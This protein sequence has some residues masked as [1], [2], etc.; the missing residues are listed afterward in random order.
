MKRLIPLMLLLFLGNAVSG[1]ITEQYFEGN[2]LNVTYYDSEKSGQ[3]VVSCTVFDARGKAVY[4]EMAFLKGY[5]ANVSFEIG[6]RHRQQELTV[7]CD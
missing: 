2:I 3:L 5:V 7:E 1:E 4:G 6:G